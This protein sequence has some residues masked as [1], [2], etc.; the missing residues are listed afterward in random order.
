M[1]YRLL[2]SL[3]Y[4]FFCLV[5]NMKKNKLLKI[6]IIVFLVFFISGCFK[7]QKSDKPAESQYL[8]NNKNNNQQFADVTE[9]KPKKEG[10]K[11]SVMEILQPGWEESNIASF[12]NEIIDLTVS[13]DYLDFHMDF[14]IALELIEQGQKDNNQTKIN[15]GFSKINQLKSQ[16]EWF[17]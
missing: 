16:Y 9:S 8:L 11:S 3:A 4:Y 5:F 1:F 15:Q 14:V 7:E 2:Q 17:N 12:K 6:V 10:Y 13:A